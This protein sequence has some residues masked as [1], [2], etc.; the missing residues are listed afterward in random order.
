MPET[1]ENVVFLHRSLWIPVGAAQEIL[2]FMG[3]LRNPWKKYGFHH[4]E[5]AARNSNP[6]RFT[7]HREEAR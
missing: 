5:L 7:A 1:L 3:N 6:R 2:W 4:P